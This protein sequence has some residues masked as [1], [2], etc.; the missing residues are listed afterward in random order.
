[1]EEKSLRFRKCYYEAIETYESESE[2]NRLY[3]AVFEYALSDNDI[4]IYLT[5]K[6]RG[7]FLLIKSLI[8]NDR[9]F[10]LYINEQ[11]STG[12]ND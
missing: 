9:L 7:T 6:I 2:R 5:P 10:D 11:G 12:D 3:R 1:M 8:D 4:S